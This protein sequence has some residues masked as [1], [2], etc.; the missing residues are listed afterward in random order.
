MHMAGAMLAMNTFNES[1][2]AIC[3]RYRYYRIDKRFIW[4]S[5]IF[6]HNYLLFSSKKLKN[7]PLSQRS[8]SSTFFFSINYRSI[9]IT[10]HSFVIPVLN[11]TS[12][13]IV[14]VICCGNNVQPIRKHMRRSSTPCIMQKKTQTCCLC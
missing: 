13:F 2:K 9:A 1:R 6:I 11:Y 12:R 8:L 14:I 4:Y 7:I 5:Q 3:S 10:D